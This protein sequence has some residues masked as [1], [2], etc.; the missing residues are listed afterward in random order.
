VDVAE[1]ALLGDPELVVAVGVTLEVDS[2][3]EI[4]NLLLC[5]KC[6]MKMISLL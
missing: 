6:T 3:E 5:P 4:R 2:I 1:V